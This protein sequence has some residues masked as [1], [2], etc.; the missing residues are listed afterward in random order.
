M[1]E[2][3]LGTPATRASIIEVLL[4]REYVVRNGKNLEATD[5][6]VPTDRSGAS[7]SEESRDDGPVGSFSEAHTTR[8]GALGAVSAG[9]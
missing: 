8:R 1:K 6:G 5:K 7:G 9:D 3:G 4:K 2:T